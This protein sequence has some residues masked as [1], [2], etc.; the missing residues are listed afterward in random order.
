MENIEIQL[1][2]SFFSAGQF[3]AYEGWAHPRRTLDSSVLFLLENGSFTIFEDDVPIRVGPHE[4]IILQAGQTHY[5]IREQRDEEPV[6]F[7]AHFA[8]GKNELPDQK[9]SVSQLATGVD[10]NRMVNMFHQ[11]VSESRAANAHPLSCDYMMSQLLI[12]M[13]IP[14][15]TEQ[16]NESLY[17]RVREYLK[18]NYRRNITVAELAEFFHYSPDYLSRLFKKHS[19]VSIHTYLHRMRLA[20]AKTELLST[21]KSVKEIAYSC[22]YTNEKHFSTIFLKYESLSPTAFRNLY[23]TLHQNNT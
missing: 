9:I 13:S 8:P 14:Q 12:A 23:K 11:L 22:G 16:L 5:G 4:A 6:Y 18:L 15:N 3:V 17:I 19:K 1:P 2:V 21:V 20:Q 10:Y 7:W